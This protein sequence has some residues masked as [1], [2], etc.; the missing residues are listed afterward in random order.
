[1]SQQ[2]ADV[3]NVKIMIRTRDGQQFYAAAWQFPDKV[4]ASDVV[5]IIVRE[6]GVWSGNI[7][8]AAPLRFVFR[9]HIASIEFKAG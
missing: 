3:N 1:M 7:V 2:Y 6:D 5:K 4:K 9:S 8:D